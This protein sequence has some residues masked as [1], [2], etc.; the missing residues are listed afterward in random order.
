M[1]ASLRKRLL[2]PHLVDD[3]LLVRRDMIEKLHRLFSFSLVEH[4]N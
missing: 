4:F 1:F 3:Q 2:V